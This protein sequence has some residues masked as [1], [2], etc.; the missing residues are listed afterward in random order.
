[1]NWT[2]V[3]VTKELWV[4]SFLHL[5]QCVMWVGFAST[6]LWFYYFQ[7]L[8]FVWKNKTK[9]HRLYMIRVRL[10]IENLLG[11]VCLTGYFF[12]ICKL[13]NDVFIFTRQ[14]KNGQGSGEGHHGSSDSFKRVSRSQLSLFVSWNSY[15]I[16]WN[17]SGRL[18]DCSDHEILFCCSFLPLNMLSGFEVCQFFLYQPCRH[19]A[20]INECVFSVKLWN[21]EHFWN[22]RYIQF[23]NRFWPERW[24]WHFFFF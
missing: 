16:L 6:M 22:C 5:K 10:I 13:P 23:F 12:D 21:A 15:E 18:F 3:I 20:L 24:S 19:H 7:K 2:L 1:M 14:C 4:G 9:K 17:V 11:R 8:D